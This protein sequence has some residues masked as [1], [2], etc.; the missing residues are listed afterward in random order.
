[1]PYLQNV[2]DTSITIMW[3]TGA[4]TTSNSV[5]WGTSME[6]GNTTMGDA[7]GV[8]HEVKME[9]L[10]P[11]TAYLY[12][13][14]SDNTESNIYSFHTSVG[15]GEPFTFVAYGDSREYGTTG[16]MPRW[17]PGESQMHSPTLS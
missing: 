2:T 3:K 9:G 10:E 16:S 15:K 17:W 11:S 6:L 1:G 13:V 8:W 7:G 4:E 5:E 14:R 12:R